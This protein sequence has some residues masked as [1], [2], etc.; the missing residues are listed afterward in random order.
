MILHFCGTDFTDSEFSLRAALEKEFPQKQ[1]KAT[2]KNSSFVSFVP[3]CS[4]KIR[5]I[6][7]SVVKYSQ[8]QTTLTDCGMTDERN[9]HSWLDGEFQKP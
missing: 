7:Q 1:T 5:S 2:K 3:F 6:L 8:E 9:Q 4:K